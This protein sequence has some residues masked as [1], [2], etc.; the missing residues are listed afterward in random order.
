[1][2]FTPTKEQLDEIPKYINQHTDNYGVALRVKMLIEQAE[3]VQKIEHEI[4]NSDMSTAV[5][6]IIKIIKG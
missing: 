5:E 6:K 2:A 4:D 3:K 1:M